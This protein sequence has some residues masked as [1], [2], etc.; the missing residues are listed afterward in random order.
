METFETTADNIAKAQEVSSP[1]PNNAQLGSTLTFYS[2]DTSLSWGFRLNALQLGASLVFNDCEGYLVWPNVLSIGDINNYENDDWQLEI[3]SGPPL[4]AF[5]FN[6]IND[7]DPY[8]YIYVYGQGGTLLGSTHD[9]PYCLYGGDPYPYFFGLIS[10]DPISK[11]YFDEDV[12]PDDIGISDFRF[13]S[14]P[15]ANP[16]PEPASGLLLVAGLS[17]L[18]CLLRRNKQEV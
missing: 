16:I 4:Y 12:G 13:A 10:T 18:A 2:T 14:I 17:G 6:L 3:L 9:L 8:D 15:T 7:N 11:I 1:P 5:A